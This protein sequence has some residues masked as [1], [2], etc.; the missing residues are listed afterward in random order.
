VK[1]KMSVPPRVANDRLAAVRAGLDEPRPEA[2]RPEKEG[3]EIAGVI[4]RVEPS[5]YDAPIVVLDTGGGEL[6]SVWCFHD[7]LKSQFERLRPG[8]GDA[9]AIRYLGYQKS[10]NNRRYKAYTVTTDKPRPEY[11]WGGQSQAA[12]AEP[13]ED[14]GDGY[15]FDD[16]EP[17]P[18]EPDDETAY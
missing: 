9:V 14:D 16:S 4:V 3:D 6:R 5:D 7:A 18:P 11:Q 17:L 8:R 10:S 12:A 1:E 15:G 2:W 13:P